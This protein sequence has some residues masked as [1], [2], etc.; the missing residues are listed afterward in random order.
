MRTFI[1]VHTALETRTFHDL[2]HIC[3]RKMVGLSAFNVN[4]HTA[5]LELG[6]IPAEMGRD[7]GLMGAQRFMNGFMRQTELRS[8]FGCVFKEQRFRLL[9]HPKSLSA[10][11]GRPSLQSPRHWTPPSSPMLHSP[12]ISRPKSEHRKPHTLNTDTHADGPF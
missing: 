5:N 7:E 9:L 3:S 1:R 12:A 11:R 8:L 2:F 4:N 6:G 10:P